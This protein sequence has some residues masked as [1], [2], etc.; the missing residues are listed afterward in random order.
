MRYRKLRIAWSMFWGLACVLLIVLWIRSYTRLDIVTYRVPGMVN[1]YSV[2]GHVGVSTQ[3][4]ADIGFP[5][6]PMGWS[7]KCYSSDAADPFPKNTVK[8]FAF[9]TDR[10]GNH[11]Q[12]AYW[13]LAPFSVTLSAIPWLPW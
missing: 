2:S 12:V 13:L 4:D 9:K 5:N 8:G 11:L 6:F 7:L 3:G 10:D 1:A